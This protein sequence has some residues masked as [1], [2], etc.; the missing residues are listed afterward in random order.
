MKNSD[1]I[2]QLL[3]EV[4]ANQGRMREKIC[5][6]CRDI[7]HGDCHDMHCGTMDVIQAQI[8]RVRQALSLL[9]CKT[10]NDTGQIRTYPC[11]GGFGFAKEILDTCP[12]CQGRLE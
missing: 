6:K 4:Y 7:G 2:R 8:I 10:C 3:K 9:P 11:S 1:Q 5:K 12:D